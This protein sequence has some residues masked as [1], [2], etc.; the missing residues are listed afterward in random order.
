MM[1]EKWSIRKRE[2]QTGSYLS[3]KGS[4]DRSGRFSL[5][6]LGFW[7]M[8]VLRP[9]ER[10]EL[11]WC[12]RT[13][14]QNQPSFLQAWHL[15]FLFPLDRRKGKKIRNKDRMIRPVVES[16]LHSGSFF[17]TS[18]L[19]QPWTGQQDYILLV[20]RLAGSCSILLDISFPLWAAGKVSIF[21]IM[22][23]QRLLKRQE[24]LIPA[25]PAISL[26][27]SWLFIHCFLFLLISFL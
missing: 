24:G 9:Q 19:W 13:F 27:D 5:M 2:S 18:V 3:F 21:C 16:Q 4:L 15:H 22:A 8:K 10:Q 12:G 26:T 14:I 11:L 7:K 25:F 23:A 6:M 20:K 1:N 17:L